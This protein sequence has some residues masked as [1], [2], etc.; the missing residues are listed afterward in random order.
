MPYWE[1]EAVATGVAH[2][3]GLLMHEAGWGSIWR[4]GEAARHKAVHKA[5]KLA[6]GENLVGWLYVGG[7]PQ[8]DEKPKPRKPIDLTRH[9]S[10]L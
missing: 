10:A 7:I 6:K 5:L 2:Y 9:F 3:M 4:T 1:Q 8:R